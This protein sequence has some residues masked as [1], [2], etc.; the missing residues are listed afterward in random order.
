MRRTRVTYKSELFKPDGPLKRII[1]DPT[2]RNIGDT[3]ITQM[4][5]FIARGQSPVRDQGR[6][7]GYKAQQIS[8]GKGRR[9]NENKQGYPYSV[10]HRFPN[11]KVRPVNLKLTGEM[12]SD[13]AHKFRFGE[14]T[15][16]LGLFSGKSA[17]KA[18]THNQG[19]QE[20]R[21]SR[22]PFLP[23]KDGESFAETIQRD[24]IAIV[25]RRI[26]YIIRSIK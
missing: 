22:R 6:F 2:A 3:V 10:M 21:I 9:G 5:N 11:K 14:Q 20:P 12:L 15:I 16:E 7:Q 19:T 13:L 18:E 1:D 25:K 8:G 4:K 17:L 24:I 23:T 26:S